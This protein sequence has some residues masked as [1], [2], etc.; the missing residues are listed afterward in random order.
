M[1]PMGHQRRRSSRWCLPLAAALVAASASADAVLD[2]ATTALH[3]PTG[4]IRAGEVGLADDAARY[5]RNAEAL[6]AWRVRALD[7]A[8]ARMATEAEAGRLEEAAAAAIDAHAVA[9]DPA[10]VLENPAVVDLVQ[11]MDA[12]ARA[13][14]AGADFVTAASLFGRLNL[15]YERSD[16]YREDAERVQHHVGLVGLYRPAELARQIRER[17]R[18][19]GRDLPE[20]PEDGDAGPSWEDRLA[21]IDRGMAAKAMARAADTHI[22]HR[23]YG[24]PLAGGLAALRALAE[25]PELR[26]EFAGL[27]DEEPR[28]AWVDRLVQLESFAR[29]FGDDLGR[30]R[31][32]AMLAEALDGARSLVPE[33]VAVHEFAQ[34]RSRR[35]TPS[36]GCSGRRTS[37]S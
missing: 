33:E 28:K 9:E 11:R 31:A 3:E 35:S 29:T 13:A 34:G 23:G 17:D 26:A 16:R 32:E 27:L 7:R 14:E 19:L 1:T 2:A 21:G 24:P 8:L 30:D 4:A 36:P 20:V 15:L 12:T 5:A 25:T 18:R 22:L 10:T 37:T 6:D